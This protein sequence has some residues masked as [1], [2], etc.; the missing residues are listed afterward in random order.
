MSYPIQAPAGRNV[1]LHDQSTQQAT[2]DWPEDRHP[3]QY[4]AYRTPP[5][6][7]AAAPPY[8]VAPA[9]YGMLQ[10]ATVP[11]A[12]GAPALGGYGARRRPG[13]VTAAAVLAFVFGGLGILFS[14]VF[15][16]LFVLAVLATSES[17]HAAPWGSGLAA[18]AYVVVLLG[19]A[20]SGLFVWGGVS[21]VRG[22]GRRM[23]VSISAIQVILVL[24]ELVHTLAGGTA[25]GPALVRA[26]LGLVFAVPILIL[27][28]QPSS[29]DFFRAR[30]GGTT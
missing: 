10:Y 18:V 19:I 30:R 15:L 4:P 12:Y 28:L 24:L 8:A 27:I 3:G 20:A 26:L 21:A 23:L 14:L 7:Y 13:V 9:Q 29:G 2:I 11:P 6:P 25:A 17:H 5:Q 1:P 22:R 16:S